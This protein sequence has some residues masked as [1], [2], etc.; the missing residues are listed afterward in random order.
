[1]AW[2]TSGL[3]DQHTEMPYSLVLH[4]GY[5]CE[6]KYSEKQICLTH[7]NL[8]NLHLLLNSSPAKTWLS[9]RNRIFFHIDRYHFDDP[10][11]SESKEPRLRLLEI[12]ANV[13]IYIHPKFSNE[14]GFW[15]RQPKLVCCEATRLRNKKPISE[16]AA[17]RCAANVIIQGWLK[18]TNK[19]SFF[20]G[21]MMVEPTSG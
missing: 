19:K 6:V 2:K 1:M 8:Y 10:S 13:A 14:L 4:Q 12:E 11:S 9:T 17:F 7:G 15:H 20:Y 16:D 5:C 3:R 21:T 18:I